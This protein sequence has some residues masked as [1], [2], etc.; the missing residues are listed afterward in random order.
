M[1]RLEAVAIDFSQTTCHVLATTD[2]RLSVTGH[3]SGETSVSYETATH[4]AAMSDSTAPG[5]AL[6]AFQPCLPAGRVRHSRDVRWPVATLPSG[7]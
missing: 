3:A 1:V 4:S 7:C 6:A 2:E 5:A